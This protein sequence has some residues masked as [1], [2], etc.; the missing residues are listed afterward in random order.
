[1]VA[2]VVSCLLFIVA[3]STVPITGRK[4]LALVP[5]SQMRSMSFQSYQEF[6]AEHPLSADA[7]ATAMVRRVGTDIQRAVEAYFTENDM[8]DRLKGYQWE[9]NLVEDPQVNA[10]CMPGG[11]V[12]VYTGLLPVT[13]DDTGLAVVLGHEIAH[14][15]ADHGNERMSQQLM[16]ELGGMALSEALKDHPA[17]TKDMLLNAYGT[18]TQVGVLLPYSRTHELEA[19]RLGLLF[20]AMAG[21]NPE[22]ALDF[23]Q[24]MAAQ[25]N[26]QSIE[27]LSTHPSNQRRIDQIKKLLPEVMP[28][29]RAGATR[30]ELEP[31]GP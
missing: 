22:K 14:A 20:M 30:L 27:L 10:W 23:W 16:T 26:G 15:V 12:V 8:S 7:Q 31:A 24:R 11:K 1:M 13:Q 17:R 28:Y 9:F 21:Y 2:I 29:Y 3:C 19:D 25:S 6:L 4:Q 5:G 18:G